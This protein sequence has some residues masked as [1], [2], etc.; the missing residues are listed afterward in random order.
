MTVLDVART[1]VMTAPSDQTAGNLATVMREEGVGSVIIEADD[2]PVGIVTDRDLVLQ[3]LEPREDPTGVTAEDVMTETLVTVQGDD[4]VFEAT[5]TMF[6]NNVRRLPVV[7]EDGSLAGI[8][9]MDD[10]L[11]LLSTEMEHLTGV[12]EAESPPY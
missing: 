10:L 9:T 5:A 4:G 2:E 6:E 7:D 11:V 8:V 3:V 12:V 1:G